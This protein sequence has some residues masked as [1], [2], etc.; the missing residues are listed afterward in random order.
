MKLDCENLS[1]WLLDHLERRSKIV[2]K[3]LFEEAL[4]LE[5]E[6]EI[7]FEAGGFGGEVRILDRANIMEEMTESDVDC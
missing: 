4:E 1:P 2:L 3:S 7:E 6:F 5:E